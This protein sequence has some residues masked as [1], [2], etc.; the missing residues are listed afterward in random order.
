MEIYKKQWFKQD[1]SGFL[2]HLTVGVRRHVC[3]LICVPGTFLLP[4]IRVFPHQHG[5]RGLT[6]VNS[7]IKSWEEM[8]V[9]RRECDPLPCRITT[10]K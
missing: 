5:P 10:Q 3:C 8:Q 6:R 7:A 4:D 2:S 1:R 9:G